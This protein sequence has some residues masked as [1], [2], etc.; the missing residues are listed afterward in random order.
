MTKCLALFF[1]N[2]HTLRFTFARLKRLRR[3]MKKSVLCQATGWRK[4]WLINCLRILVL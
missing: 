2:S 3:I 4:F 1:V